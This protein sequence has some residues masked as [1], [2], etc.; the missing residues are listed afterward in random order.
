M[1]QSVGFTSAGISP[2]FTATATLCILAS[3]TPMPMEMLSLGIHTPLIIFVA[4][5]STPAPGTT[6]DASATKPPNIIEANCG[7]YDGNT[8]GLLV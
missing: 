5:P 1:I 2:S 4:S 8:A 3:N 6:S 7:G